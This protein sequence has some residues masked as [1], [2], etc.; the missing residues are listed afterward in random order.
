[1]TEQLIRTSADWI[2]VFRA[3]MRQLGL[4]HLEVDA[5]AG[6]S[7]GHCGKIMCGMRRPTLATIERLCGA[8]DLKLV[9]E[10]TG[11]ADG[12]VCVDGASQITDVVVNERS[13]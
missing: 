6:L 8:L 5:R 11:I 1:M 2:P 12:Q 4:T 13:N 7:D 3:R 9:L 10:P